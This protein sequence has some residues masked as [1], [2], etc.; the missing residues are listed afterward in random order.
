[1]QGENIMKPFIKAGA[2]ALVS[3]SLFCAF[4]VPAALAD[5]MLTA[6]NGMTLYIFDKDQSGMSECYGDC[7]KHWPPY[8]AKKGTKLSEGWTTV[9]RKDGKM[10][11]AYDGKPVYFY[12]DDK[13]KGDM[14]GDGV[15]GVWHVI[16]E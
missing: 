1:M 11:L 12:M 2:F 5:S 15:G 7:A 13:K 6:K 8:L 16:K 14:K 4:A 10:Q 3:A 9:K